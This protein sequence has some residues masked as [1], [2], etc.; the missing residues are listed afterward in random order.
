MLRTGEMLKM[1]KLEN[2]KLSR[3]PTPIKKIRLFNLVEV[4]LLIVYLFYLRW[5]SLKQKRPNPISGREGTVSRK[6]Q[7]IFHRKK[8]DKPNFNRK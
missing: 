3:K 2:R 7:P 8:K 5:G 4:F 6:D 1:L